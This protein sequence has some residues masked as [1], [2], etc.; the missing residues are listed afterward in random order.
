MK[1][2]KIAYYTTY[3]FPVPFKGLNIYPVTVKD[4]LTFSMYSQCLTIDKNSIPDVK[5]IS[6]TDL[7]YIYFASTQKE[8]PYLIW[9]DRL[10]SL[11][12]KN[13]KSFENVEESIKRYKYDKKG[14]PF[15]EIDNQMYWSEDFTEIQNI[16]SEQNDIELIDKTISKEVRDSLEKAREYR[17]KIT[18]QT[19]ASFED[20]IISVASITGWSFEYI[21][22]MTIRK[23]TRVVQR[24]DNYIHYKIYLAASMSGMVEFKDKSFIKHWLS[25]LNNENK[26]EDVSMDLDA[27]QEKISLESAK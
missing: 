14:K 5:I 19:Q 10:L 22:S 24:L 21:Y 8:E 6:M 7:E 18:G 13:D 20:Y 17:N 4:Y 26:Y 12:L 1:S 3:D 11:C 25:D 2:G 27:V 15:F 16:I 23:F 9:F